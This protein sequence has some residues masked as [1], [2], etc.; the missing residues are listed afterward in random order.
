MSTHQD[1]VQ[2][3][4]VLVSAVMGT[5]GNGTF[6]TLIGMTVHIN[7]L[8]CFGFGNSMVRN[9]GSMQTIFSNLAFYR[10]LWYCVMQETVKQKLQY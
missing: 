2:G 6:D 8:L 7:D 4:V 9:S 1:L 5:L 3:A 10:F